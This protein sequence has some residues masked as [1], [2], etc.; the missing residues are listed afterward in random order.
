[1]PLARIGDTVSLHVRA[2]I[3]ELDIARVRVGQ[4]VDVRSDAFAGQS[5]LQGIHVSPA[6]GT[7]QSARVIPAEKQDAKILEALILLEV[8]PPCSMVCASCLIDTDEPQR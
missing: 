8:I 3:D 5:F 2:D 7:T 6:H 1:M 4:T